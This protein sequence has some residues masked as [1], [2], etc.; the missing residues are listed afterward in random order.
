MTDPTTPP[1]AMTAERADAIRESGARAARDAIK[2]ALERHGQTPEVMA[3]VV[4]GL[5]S[6]AVG[7]AWRNRLDSTTDKA[8]KRVFET[9]LAKAMRTALSLF[10][11]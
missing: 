5:F 9:I 7:I 3:A 2:G 1:K 6:G 11:S 8:F 10:R 4:E